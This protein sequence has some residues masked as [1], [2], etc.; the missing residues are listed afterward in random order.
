VRQV[1]RLA[2]LRV[3]V[4]SEAALHHHPNLDLF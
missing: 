2:A 3:D 1:V 4:H